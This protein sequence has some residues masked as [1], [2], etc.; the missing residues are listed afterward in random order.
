M[1]I[2]KL[3]KKYKSR[4]RVL[5]PAIAGAIIDN[6]IEHKEVFSTFVQLVVNGN[7]IVIPG[8]KFAPGTKGKL[9]AFEKYVLESSLKGKPTD[10]KMVV[11]RLEE[12]DLVHFSSL[13]LEE[14]V[15][16]G[17]VEGK[18]AIMLK[19]KKGSAKISQSM[20]VSKCGKNVFITKTKVTR[21]E[22]MGLGDTRISGILQDEKELEKLMKGGNLREEKREGIGGAIL[23]LL[24]GKKKT[25][26]VKN[27][28]FDEKHKILK[29]DDSFENMEQ[30]FEEMK[31]EM[32]TETELQ[33]RTGALEGLLVFSS[34]DKAKSLILKYKE[35]Q[36]FLSEHPL[37]ED[38]FSNEF[39]AYNIAFHLRD[40]K[41]LPS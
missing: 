33:G 41:S 31:K 17:L 10:E 35:L 8:R 15:S 26:V 13:L 37:L 18:A 30:I 22:G 38:R 6:K 12:M 29:N 34:S 5:K 20:D 2:D 24:L 11:N 9:L 16:R 4:S 1:D 32:G 39:V 19:G 14:L 36:K 27:I 7:I 21:S 28:K 23:D 25:F 40:T 3:L